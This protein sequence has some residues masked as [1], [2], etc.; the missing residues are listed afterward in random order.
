[1]TLP[2][3][4]SLN[5]IAPRPLSSFFLLRAIGGPPPPSISYTYLFLLGLPLLFPKDI[6]LNICFA[7]ARVLLAKL[8]KHFSYLSEVNGQNYFCYLQLH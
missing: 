6:Q 5:S 1:M 7:H 2:I 3:V 4:C 8:T